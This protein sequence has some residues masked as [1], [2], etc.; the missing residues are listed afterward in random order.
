M[1]LEEQTEQF[2]ELTEKL[3]TLGIP[4]LVD[5]SS[6]ERQNLESRSGSR[7]TVFSTDVKS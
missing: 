3:A 7:F 2:E 5:R 6:E 4:V 1:T